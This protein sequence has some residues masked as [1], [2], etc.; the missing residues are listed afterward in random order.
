MLSLA[1]LERRTK[2]AASFDRLHIIHRNKKLLTIPPYIHRHLRST[3]FHLTTTKQLEDMLCGTTPYY[4][5]VSRTSLNLPCSLFCSYHITGEIMLCWNKSIFTCFAAS[6][7]TLLY[8]LQFA[9]HRHHF[10]NTLDK[11]RYSGF[12]AILSCLVSEVQGLSSSG[13]TRRMCELKYFWYYLKFYASL[14]R[15]IMTII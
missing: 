13:F 15:L 1:M 2:L 5:A 10:F 6:T 8:P 14:Q 12:A 9:S 3:N 11:M 7:W 4:I